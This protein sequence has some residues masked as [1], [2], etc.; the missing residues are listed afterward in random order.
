[1]AISS[2]T[3]LASSIVAADGPFCSVHDLLFDTDTWHIRY[4][5]VDTGGW[6]HGRRV[7]LSP[8]IVERCDWLNH[9][10][11]VG[12][13][14]QQVEDSPPVETVP[15]ISHEGE[16]ALARHYA[17]TAYWLGRS[18]AAGSA[19]HLQSVREATG[20]AVE[21]ADGPVG[22]VED[23]IVDD[24]PWGNGSWEIRYLVVELR[25]WFR[26][27]RV[28]V[29]PVWADEIDWE[30]RKLRLGVPRG[31]IQESPEFDPGE[32]VNREAEQRLY[33]YYGLPKYWAKSG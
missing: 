6:L 10:I 5:V 26:H 11:A 33:D 20:S 3:I 31:Q 9:E 19:S 25:G 14:R 8:S 13:T 32:P 1:M 28:L 2:Q 7:L 23:F 18:P 12:S 24:N 22:S 4:V 17:W 15:P 16:V 27:K 30:G 21:A 29:A